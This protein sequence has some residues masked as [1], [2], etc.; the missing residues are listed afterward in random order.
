[1]KTLNEEMLANVSGGSVWD[2]VGDALEYLANGVVE[3]IIEPAVDFAADSMNGFAT[4]MLDLLGNPSKDILPDN[5][6]PGL[7]K[8]IF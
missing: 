2:Y 3:Y 8:D 6:A 7:F 5:T 1:M 4:T